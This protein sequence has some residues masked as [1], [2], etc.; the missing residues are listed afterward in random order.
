MTGAIRKRRAIELLQR[1]LD[2]IAVLKGNSGGIGSVEFKKWQRNT[3]VAIAHIFGDGARHVSD[4]KR[5][6]YIPG[7]VSLGGGRRTDF[8]GP[9]VRGLDSAVS[10]LQSMIDEISEY[11]SGDEESATGDVDDVDK[12]G[13][14]VE[15]NEVFIVHGRD[16]GPK[17]AVARFLE[18]LELS[19][20]IL[21]EQANEG[22][23]IIEK[24]EQHSQVG[25]AVVLL[26]PEDVGRLA[27]EGDS[28]LR[29]RA[30][31]NV[32]LELGFFLGKLGRKRTCALLVGD[33][34]IPSDY[35]GVLYVSMD[36]Q[37]AWKFELVRELKKA[38]FD[39]DAN[40]IL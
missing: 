26:T 39:V 8:L 36:E 21:H 25:F 3:E 11:W 33:V 38:G 2:E 13:I 37:D 27:S 12:D 9:Y 5:I 32:I 40:R 30:R 6:R 14:Q 15:S 7:V 10:V 31:Q 24:F 22:L 28:E 19:P 16:D 23:T 20:I 18:R 17:Q 4:F 1:A 35:A 34:E 29:P